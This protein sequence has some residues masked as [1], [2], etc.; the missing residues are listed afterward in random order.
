MLILFVL[1]VSRPGL[2][3]ASKR[4]KV[5]LPA[6]SQSQRAPDSRVYG[7]RSSLWQP[8]FGARL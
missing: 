2:Y 7:Q 3:E 4:N 8:L 5:Y 6:V 1:A